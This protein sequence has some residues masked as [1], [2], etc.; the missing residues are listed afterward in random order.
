M[1]LP[2]GCGTFRTKTILNRA[3]TLNFLTPEF[4]VE[5]SRAYWTEVKAWDKEK[6]ES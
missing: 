3:S 2:L 1:S 4:M 5:N 6:I